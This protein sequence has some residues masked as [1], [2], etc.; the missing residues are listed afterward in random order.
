MPGYRIW[1]EHFGTPKKPIIA[2]T[3]VMSGCEPVFLDCQEQI[4]IGEYSFCGH[5]VKILTGSHDYTK[6]NHD[7]QR[8]LT[9]KPVTIGRGVWI[10]SFAIILP[11]VTIGDHSVVGAG[12]LVSKNIPSYEMWVGNPAKVIKKIPH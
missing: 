6:F 9:P 8:A 11:G 2:D 5:G 4:T 12:A 1:G 7:R 3:V 10:A